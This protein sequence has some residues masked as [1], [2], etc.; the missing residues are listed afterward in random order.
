M[1]RNEMTKRILH[2]TLEI[3]HLLTREDYT[4]VKKTWRECMSPSSHLHESGGRSRARGPITEP[5]PLSLIHEKKILEL[6]HRITELLTREVPIRCQDVAVYFSMEEWEYV[7][8]HK[9]LYQD[10]VMMEDHRPLASQDG[11]MERNPPET[12]P[13]PLYSQDCPEGNVSEK[14]QPENPVDIKVEAIDEAE[15]T[16]VMANQHC[17]V[18]DENPPE[19]CP[20]PLYSKDCPEGNVSEKHQDE[21]LMNIKVEVKDEPEEETDLGADQ[22]YGVIDRNPPE[23]CPRPLYS[24]DCPEGNVPE[25]HQGGDLTNNK[26]E[27]EEERMRGHHPCMRE[28]KEEIPG[29]VTPEHPRKKREGNVMLSVSDKEEDGEIME[30]SSGEDGEIM[31]RSSGE[32]GEIMERSSG[33]DLLTPNVHPDL[34]HNN[35]PDHGEPSHQPHIVTTRTEKKRI[36]CDECG[37]WFT[38]RSN[39]VRHRKSHRE[40]KPNSCCECGKC[41]SSKSQLVKHKRIHTGE[42]PYSCS[43]CGKCFRWKSH[44]VRH[45]R[46]H[47]GEKPY[48]CSECEKCFINKPQLS[49]HERTHTEEKPFSCS[50]C[51]KCFRWKSHL[52]THERSHTGVKPYSCSVCGK[53]FISKYNLFAHDKIHTGEKLYSCSE[54]GICFL[55]KLQLVKHEKRIHTGEKPFSCSE[56]GKCFRWKS[57]LVTHERSHT[58]VKPYSCSECG[59]CFIQ[60]VQLLT[61]ERSH[62]GEKPYSCLECGKCFTSKYRLVA[63]EKIHTGEKPYSCSECGKSFFSKPKLVQ[64]EKRI[65]TGEKPYS[66]SE[67]EKCFLRKSDLVTHERIHTGVKP[68]SCSKCGECF[69]SKSRLVKHEKSHTGKTPYSC[70]ECGKYFTTKWVLGKHV[71]IHTR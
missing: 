5:P 48:S 3:L 31:E 70:S 65:H 46:S 6:I 44:L 38:K 71:R 58:G 9:D 12:C 57:H 35:P 68:Y 43:E 61:H 32:D 63:H 26:V 22:Q 69:I 66:C 41:F 1:D 52:V 37:K 4:I 36:Q 20:R 53:C 23:R 45:E 16:G 64:H 55:S 49:R 40:E 18:M 56:C 54:C 30:R 51:G 15:E 10:I 7:E 60:K 19:R 27:D 59:K 8:G 13:R 67:C 14:H 34:S 24:Q 25:K 29:G 39:L 28:V 42:M 62:T 11:V 33:E 2:F 47:I 21:D 17:V 50:E